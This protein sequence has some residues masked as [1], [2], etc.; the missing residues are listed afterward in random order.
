MM[1]I[2]DRLEKELARK[3]AWN[4]AMDAG[5]EELRRLKAENAALKTE[6]E[7]TKR[8]LATL[9]AVYEAEGGRESYG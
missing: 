6:L 9:Q 1:P 4:A 2:V 7:N 5:T 3:K 8:A